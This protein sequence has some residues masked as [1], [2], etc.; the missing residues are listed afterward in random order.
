PLRREGHVLE[1]TLQGPDDSFVANGGA[2]RI[3]FQ[4]IQA[5]DDYT[6]EIED[7]K[8]ALKCGEYTPWINLRFRSGL[9]VTIHGIARFLLTETAPDVSIYVTPIQMDPEKPALPISQPS[10][11]AMYLAKLLGSF[12]TLGM[13][14]DTWALNE[15]AIDEAA[16]LKQADL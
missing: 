1:G 2:M 4:L 12:A 11:Y 7:Q 15:G 3:D 6:L 10:Y 9:G 8:H 16:F 5:G 14:E 13:A